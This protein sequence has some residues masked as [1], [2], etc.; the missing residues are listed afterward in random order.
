VSLMPLFPS[1][2]NESPTETSN[3]YNPL[4]LLKFACVGDV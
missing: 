3:L 1:M 2:T 4:L